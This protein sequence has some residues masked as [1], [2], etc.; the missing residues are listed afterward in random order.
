MNESDFLFRF[1][2]LIL[3]VEGVGLALAYI[4]LRLPRLAERLTNGI[5][6]YAGQLERVI[7]PSINRFRS[8]FV[9]QVVAL[10]VAILLI[11]SV[12]QISIA[13]FLAGNYFVAACFSGLTLF[14]LCW[15]SV[16][17]ISRNPIGTMGVLLAIA[18]MI[19]N[20]YQFVAL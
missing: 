15:L 3:C 16:K 14:C 5:T 9:Q 2:V 6:H 8:R 11:G 19:A 7:E 1:N 10:L 20:L 12:L 13:A 17:W 4:E 18:G